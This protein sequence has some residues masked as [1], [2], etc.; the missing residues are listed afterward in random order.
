MPSPVPH[1]TVCICTYKRPQL[2]GRLLEE[3][4]A[5]HTAGLFTY[6][7]VVVDNDHLRSAEPIV[8]NFAAESIACVRYCVESRQGIS[9]ARNMAVAN[10]TG[11]LI[12]FI[13]DDELPTQCWLLT[14]FKAL[15]EYKSDG[16]L[17]CVRP[18]FDVE[19]PR[20]LVKG[21]FYERPTYA[22]GFVIDWQQGRTGNVLLKRAILLVDAQPF[23]PEFRSGE[24]Q[25]FFRRMIGQGKVFIWCNESVVHEVIPPSR[26][27]RVLMLKR[28]LLQGA[29]SAVHPTFRWLNFAKS[30]IAVPVYAAALPIAL[31]FGHHILM[32]CLIK[33]CDHL[34][35]LL[36]LVGVDPIRSAYITE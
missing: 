30:A 12:A 2:L 16:V 4:S 26:W 10:A 5:Q 14:L 22:T 35:K 8:S 11:E 15:N 36:A 34:G 9:R 33:L 13:D 31:I 27:K 1:I 25:D 7:I 23:R 28:A 20:W 3:L 6:S 17:G 21:R 32:L 18:Y 24:D 19:P 29:S